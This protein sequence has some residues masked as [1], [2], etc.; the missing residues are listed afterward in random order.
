MMGLVGIC[1]LTFASLAPA[2]ARACPD[3]PKKPTVAA[4][5]DDPKKPGV[6]ACPGDDGKGSKKPSIVAACPRDDSKKP[7][8]G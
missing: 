1:A 6:D 3:A 5:P 4:C 7:S 8:L 2:A